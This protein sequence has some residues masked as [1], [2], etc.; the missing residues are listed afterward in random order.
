[1]T[2]RTSNTIRLVLVGPP[3]GEFRLAAE[4]AR[5]AGA[6]V[7]AADT[8]GSAL[9]LLRR[10]GGDLVMI[11]VAL[12][13]P[14]F[15]NQLRADRIATPVLACGIDAP[16]ARAVA[17]VLA[18]ARDYI[19]L[20][21]ERELIAAAIMM[22]GQRVASP[23]GESPA[24]SHAIG[25]ARAIASSQAPMLIAGEPGTGKEV[26]ARMVHDASARPGRFVVVDCAGIGGDVLD[27]ELFGHDA[28]VF[29]GSLASRAGRLEEAIDGTVFL[30]E[31]GAL[32][33]PTQARLSAMLDTG[34]MDDHAGP[35]RNARLIA[36]TTRDLAA[37]VSAGTFRSDLASRLGL[38]RVDL[39]PL[40]ERGDDV[41]RLAIHF[42]AQLPAAEGMAPRPLSAPALR[43]LGQ[44]HWP[45]NVR[46]L[47][48]VIQRAA[49][50][51]TGS[52]IDSDALVLNDGS[53]IAAPR[54]A[55]AEA[56][57]GSL[58]GRSMA[59]VERELILQTLTRC[60]GNRTTAS[61]I[62]GISV[63]TMRNKLKSFIEAG[64]SIAPA[65]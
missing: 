16:A 12:D 37:Q 38:L 39:P 57:I 1:M 54:V 9:D 4:M 2:A 22:L 26:V 52:Q 61:T 5:E 8:S 50:L 21:P 36:S 27:S 65:A 33:P 48:Q 11:D 25:Y 53:Q 6:E 44:H 17:A 42:A 35:R 14:G 51:A 13:V 64:I 30:R 63:R 18:G 46:E 56:E 55:N 10:S 59:D 19:P 29:P 32:P 20:P 40:R 49:L 15:L 47:R 58:V 62:L 43:R 41:E 60:G 34:R 23:I 28:N 7:D 3:G 24:M 31:I 45:D